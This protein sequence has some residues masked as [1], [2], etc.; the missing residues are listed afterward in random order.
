MTAT[1][2]IVDGDP[3]HWERLSGVIEG[4]GISPVRCEN[5]AAASESLAHEQLECA[6]CEDA[7]PDGDFRGLIVEI[8]RSGCFMPVVVVSRVDDW[9]AY[10]EAMVAGAFDYAAFPPYPRGN[11][12]AP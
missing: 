8:R 3:Q 12:S 9:G 6:V 5:L 2:A 1:V 10:L 4:C 7:L 11:W